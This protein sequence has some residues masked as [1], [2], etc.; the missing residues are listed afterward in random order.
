[1]PAAYHHALTGF[2][3]YGHT[4][5]MKAGAST[6]GQLICNN[7]VIRNGCAECINPRQKK[8][9]SHRFSGMSSSES[10]SDKAPHKR[11]T[12][13]L[14]VA[15]LCSAKSKCNNL[16]WFSLIFAH[17]LQIST[18]F[19]RGEESSSLKGGQALT[20]QPQDDKEEVNRPGQPIAVT[21]R[22]NPYQMTR[23]WDC[24]SLDFL[25]HEGA[26]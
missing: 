24:Q 9:T 10:D 21:N 14:S 5:M 23:S 8:K 12:F 6:I 1:M 2:L 3:S 20:S 26:S 17:L 15:S 7:F 25:I 13:V 22:K 16:C 11:D 19:W 4:T 18:N